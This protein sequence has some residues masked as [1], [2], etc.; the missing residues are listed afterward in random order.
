MEPQNLAWT[1]LNSRWNVEPFTT[2][3]TEALNRHRE[4]LQTL[5]EQRDE[6]A[7]F[8]EQLEQATSTRSSSI[9][10]LAEVLELRGRV[11]EL[12]ERVQELTEQIVLLSPPEYVE[13]TEP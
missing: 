9:G 2:P 1:S 4:K 10:P 11:Q 5:R 3:A 13:V 7:R 12:R 6:V 8:Q